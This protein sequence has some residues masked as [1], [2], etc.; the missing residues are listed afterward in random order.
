MTVAERLDLTSYIDIVNLIEELHIKSNKRLN[1]C[2]LTT[3]KRAAECLFEI[4]CGVNIRMGYD[5]TLKAEI[6][7]GSAAYEIITEYGELTVDETQFREVIARKDIVCNVASENDAL[8]NLRLTLVYAPE[9]ASI[10]E[11]T[12]RCI[13]L[14]ADKAVMVINA[15]QIL[16]QTEQK[17]VGTMLLPAYSPSRLLIGIGNAQYMKPEEWTDGVSRVHRLVGKDYTVFPFFTESVPEYVQMSFAGSDVTLEA[18][19]EQT[20]KSIITVRQLHIEDLDMYTTNVLEEALSE[21][22]NKLEGFRRSGSEAITAAELDIEKLDQS[23]SRIKNYIDLFLQTPL[24]ARYRDDIENFSSLLTASLKDDIM[25]S[26]D[27]KQDARALPRYLSYVWDRFTEEQNYRLS[28]LFEKET[29]TIIDM[30]NLDL[31]KIARDTRGIELGSDLN[32]YLEGTFSVHT[33]FARKTTAGNSL[34]EAMTIGG[35]VAL[36]IAP[37]IGL[38]AILG[39]ELIKVFGK[40]KFDEEYKKE[41]V[42]KIGDVVESNM[43]ELISQADSNFKKITDTYRT[44]ILDYYDETID[45]VRKLLSK[46][47]ETVANANDTIEY[48]STLI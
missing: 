38:S 14:E 34:T 44:E 6:R 40:N 37:P 1:I 47:K 45:G 11:D 24:V 31:K 27:I 5:T 33:F 18:V 42:N 36:L 46:E 15:G 48:I 29:S 32:K 30:M 9:Y 43:K 39:S 13:L 4:L 3:N 41:L 26:A 21:L 7:Y 2:V 8:K 23:R 17:F 25:Q 10:D 19:L 12:W 20:A 28:R 16:T 22:R 35:I